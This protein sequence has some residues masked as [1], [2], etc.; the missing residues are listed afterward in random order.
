M[1]LG[2]WPDSTPRLS[3]ACMLSVISRSCPWPPSDSRRA[4]V[5]GV[6]TTYEAA[7]HWWRGTKYARILYLANYGQDATYKT[8]VDDVI[9]TAN[10]QRTSFNNQNSVDTF[11]G[12]NDFKEQLENQTKVGDDVDAR[13]KARVRLTAGPHEIGVAFIQR[14]DA[15]ST[16]RLQPFIRSSADPID[17][18]GRR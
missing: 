5:S 12:F 1:T 7:G 15:M 14:S 18:T 2:T 11:G 9:V 8:R 13:L 4:I 6:V 17:I 10:G 16:L 3:T